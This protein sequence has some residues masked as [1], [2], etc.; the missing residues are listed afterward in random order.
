MACGEEAGTVR[1]RGSLQHDTSI[2]TDDA[3]RLEGVADL[4][5]RTTHT[6]ERLMSEATRPDH[7]SSDAG[8]LGRWRRFVAA[9][10]KE[11]MEVLY[12]GGC[13]YVRNEEGHWATTDRRCNANGPR[14]SEDPLWLL[15]LIG[16]SLRLL[17]EEPAAIDADPATRHR[18]GLDLFDVARRT[19]RRP[20]YLPGHWERLLR[21]HVAAWARHVPI[22]IWIDA[23]PHIRRLAYALPP[24]SRRDDHPTWITTDLREH[25]VPVELPS[26][27]G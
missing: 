20:A 21:P 5:T 13:M 23:T 26:I 19:G 7:E 17:G 9:M 11:E 4:R 12:V 24:S 27:D 10:G 8:G 3:L 1:V 22:E 14:R 15:D 2:P 16:K 6:T 25:G 18:C